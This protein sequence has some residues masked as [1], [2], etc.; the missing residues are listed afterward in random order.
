TEKARRTKSEAP[1]RKPGQPLTPEQV[2]ELIIQLRKDTGDGYT[3]LMGRLRVLGIKLSRQTVKNILVEE[4]LQPEPND[5]PDNWDAFLKRHAET[6]WQCDFATKPMWTAKGLIDLYVLVFLH[7]GTRRCW[8]SPCTA[9]PDSAWVTQQ[10]RNF[11]MDAE[12]IR[13]AAR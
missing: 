1:K 4:G 3:K 7:L 8:I 9:N 6:L 12:D 13:Q 10:G 2:R 5:N 11:L